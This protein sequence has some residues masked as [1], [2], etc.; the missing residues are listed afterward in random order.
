MLSFAGFDLKYP[1]WIT[2]GG[3][4]TS[5]MY[6]F[7]KN[8]PG[9]LLLTT[10]TKLAF[11]PRKDLPFYRVENL[12]EL[13]SKIFLK[14]KLLAGKQVKGDKIIGF[15]PAEV[16]EFYQKYRVPVVVEADG[17]NGRPLKIHFE[18]EPAL[19]PNPETVIA[20]VGLSALNKPYSSHFIHRAAEEGKI[21]TPKTLVEL[22]V[23]GRY[24]PLNTSKKVVFLNQIDV[25][26][27]Q[28]LE[29]VLELFKKFP[30]YLVTYG[31]LREGLVWAVR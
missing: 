23:K 31:S 28:L 10:T 7:A 11:P 19:P 29:E 24:F 30:E 26:E 25:I 4:K 3:G 20:V 9:P 22:V 15:S 21:I 1:I 27:N 5:L 6:Y 8:I 2:G 12:E 16:C 13:A 18:H 14:E 17:S